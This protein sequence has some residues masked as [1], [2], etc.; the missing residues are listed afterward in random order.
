MIKACHASLLMCI[1]RLLTPKFDDECIYAHHTKFLWSLFSTLLTPQFYDQ[2]FDA[3][4]IKIRWSV[5]IG[6]LRQ[7]PMINV[8]T[9]LTSKSDVYRLLRSISD[10]Q[11]YTP[12]ARVRWSVFK[13]FWRQSPM[14]CATCNTFLK[15]ES[16]DLYF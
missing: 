4:Y 5:L 15:P 11:F 7:M 2:C 16:V 9:L 3:P 13:G 12:N 6:S 1:Y 10:D 8:A 14:I